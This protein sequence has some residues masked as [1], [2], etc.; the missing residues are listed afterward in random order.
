MP[1]AENRSR[2]GRCCAEEL[3]GQTD[4]QPRVLHSDF[5]R[6]GSGVFIGEFQPFGNGISDTHSQTVMEKYSGKNQEGKGQQHFPVQGHDTGDDGADRQDRNGR[7][8]IKQR[9]ESVMEKMS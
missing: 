2:E 1:Q 4:A 9:F 3:S 6:Q 8:D 5:K 7:K